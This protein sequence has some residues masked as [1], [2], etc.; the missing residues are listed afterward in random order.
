MDNALLNAKAEFRFMRHVKNAMSRAPFS[1][2]D[3]ECLLYSLINAATSYKEQRLSV[4]TKN[5]LLRYRS[6]LL[7]LSDRYQFVFRFVNMTT[8]LPKAKNEVANKCM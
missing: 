5:E 1:A 2:W 7:P 6:L 8:D 3:L 4:Y